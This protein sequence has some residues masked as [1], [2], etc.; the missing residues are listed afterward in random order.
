MGRKLNLARM[1]E[2][3]IKHLPHYHVQY[4]SHE[5]ISDLPG[6]V[7]DELLRE[8]VERFDQE[9]RSRHMWTKKKFRLQTFADYDI[10]YNRH[11]FIV[12]ERFI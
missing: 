4:V 3:R 7:L 5:T 1:R 9:M 10:D 6:S 11:K 12:E 8:Q 2:H